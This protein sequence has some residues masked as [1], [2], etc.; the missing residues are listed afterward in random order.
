MITCLYHFRNVSRFKGC[1]RPYVNFKLRLFPEIR[2]IYTNFQISLFLLFSVVFNMS[3]DFTKD[4]I[5]YDE[6][7]AYNEILKDIRHR[8][9]ILPSTVFH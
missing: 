5:L 6:W 8:V 4:N 1:W 3:S 7:S 9:I 2:K